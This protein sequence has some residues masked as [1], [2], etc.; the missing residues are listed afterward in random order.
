MQIQSSSVISS[1]P[2]QVTAAQTSL[3]SS[4][5]FLH[6]FC[7]YQLLGRLEGPDDSRH[8]Q[9]QL[10]KS[11]IS[12]SKQSTPQN[13][14]QL[15]L[16]ALQGSRPNHEA[17]DLALNSCLS[18]LLASPSP[19][20]HTVSI[21]IRKLVGLAGFLRGQTDGEAAAFTAY[22]QAYRIIVG[23]KEGEYPAEEGKWLATTAW[24]KAGYAVRLGH[25]ETARKWMKMGLDFAQRLQCM[26]KYKRAMEECLRSFDEH[27]C[28]SDPIDVG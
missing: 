10:I 24:N 5:F 7:A 14:L 18:S 1:S 12:S 26:E 2:T 23:L 20:Y 8:K 11:F 3:E 15:G 28:R 6:T 19:D 13:L 27:C 4:L 16:I 17:A 21:V 9:L 22:Q 25:V